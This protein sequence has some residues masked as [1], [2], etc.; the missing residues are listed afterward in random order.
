MT[1]Q[2]LKNI[3]REISGKP[4]YWFE[5]ILPLLRSKVIDGCM[6][7]PEVLVPHV[8]MFSN[9]RYV[10]PPY[11]ILSPLTVKAN[12]KNRLYYMINQLLLTRSMHICSQSLSS[13]VFYHKKTG[14]K[15]ITFILW[16]LH[17]NCSNCANASSDTLQ[18]SAFM[19]TNKLSACR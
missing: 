15:E 7:W 17:S 16:L 13:N 8:G 9:P 6:L 19:N 1:D 3:C 10:F 2:I 4:Y 5:S 11:T 18:K 12:V 14:K